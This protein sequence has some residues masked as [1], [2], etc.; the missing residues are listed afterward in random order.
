MKLNPQAINAYMDLIGIY[1]ALGSG[2]VKG[3]LFHDR[4]LNANPDSLLI[5][6]RYLHFS[7]P[8]WG[9]EFEKRQEYLKDLEHSA[10]TKPQLRGIMAA[11]YAQMAKEFD[12]DADKSA[13]LYDQSLKTEYQC[14]IHKD[15]AYMLFNHKR[16]AQSLEDL[17]RLVKKCPDYA[18]GY[19]IRGRALHKLGETGDA[20]E[21]LAM[22]LELSPDDPQ[23]LGTRGYI[24]LRNKN[25]QAAIDDL[26]LAL[27]KDKQTA[28]MWDN[29][30]Y[31]YYKLKDYHNAV[32]DFTHAISVNPESTRAYRRRGNCHKKLKSYD[33]ALADYSKGLEINPDDSKLLMQRAKLHYGNL[34]E[35]K[36]ALEDLNH[37]LSIDPAHKKAKT[38]IRKIKAKMH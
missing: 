22:A 31:A 14:R 33:L 10:L 5:R 37:I 16:Y 13:S 27:E 38:L 9:I 23:I 34:Y 2:D 7:F 32:E 8:K 35:N 17:N 29:R 1:F 12:K 6:K 30:G 19:L 20:L 4:G 3:R 11:N 25:Y 28:W 21:N 36:K 26:T 24:Q 15:K 18:S